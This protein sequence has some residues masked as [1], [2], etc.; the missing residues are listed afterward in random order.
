MRLA[1]TNVSL[2]SP[3]GKKSGRGAYVCPS[4]DCL[5]AAVKA[6]RLEKAL[7]QAISQE[8]YEQLKAGLKQP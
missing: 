3:T 1:F 6:K 2:K 5:A 7:E 8:V 4:S